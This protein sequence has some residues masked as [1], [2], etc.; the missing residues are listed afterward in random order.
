VRVRFVGCC[1]GGGGAGCALGTGGGGISVIVASRTAPSG[2][3]MSS[4][5]HSDHARCRISDSPSATSSAGRTRRRFPS[6][7]A[8]DDAAAAGMGRL[9]GRGARS[10][11]VWMAVTRAKWGRR[12]RSATGR[13]ARRR[14]HGKSSPTPF[15]RRGSRGHP[16]G[17]G[18]RRK[19]SRRLPAAGDAP[20]RGRERR[21]SQDR[22]RAA[23]A[24]P[25]ARR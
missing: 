8:G 19:T 15:N 17:A 25:P 21:A 23:R 3:S 6:L 1:G 12:R 22:R 20:A 13:R 18:G 14:R 2:V 9:T 24:L 10:S 16:R 7:S 11:S 4:A 5:G